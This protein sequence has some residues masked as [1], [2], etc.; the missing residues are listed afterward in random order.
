MSIL[1]TSKVNP[2]NNSS[3]FIWI[4]DP[5]KVATMLDQG[6]WLVGIRYGYRWKNHLMGFYF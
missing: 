5:E 2:D 4:I 1:M 3:V 6:W